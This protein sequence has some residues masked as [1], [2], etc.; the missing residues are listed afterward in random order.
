MKYKY[1][2]FNSVKKVLPSIKNILATEYLTK[3]SATYVQ[4]V[5]AALLAMFLKSK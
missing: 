3:N 1:Q 4:E 5:T 2:H